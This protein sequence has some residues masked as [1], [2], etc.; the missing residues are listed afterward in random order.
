MSSLMSTGRSS[1]CCKRSCRTTQASRC[2]APTTRFCGFAASAAGDHGAADR[3]CLERHEPPRLLPLDREHDRVGGGIGCGHLAVLARLKT[4]ALR[5]REAARET[6][7]LLAIRALTV[8]V[9]R[10]SHLL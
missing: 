10:E 2:C 7:Q 6:L 9:D 1:T 4:D 5:H 8:P 3:H